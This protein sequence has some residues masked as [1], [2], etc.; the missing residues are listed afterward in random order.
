M[1]AQSSYVQEIEAMR[2]HGR[3]K[4]VTGKVVEIGFFDPKNQ[5]PP[6][7]IS[8]GLFIK[9]DHIMVGCHVRPSGGDAWSADRTWSEQVADDWMPAGSQKNNNMSQKS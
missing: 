2:K 5:P 8:H 7:H 3:V 6:P 1:K 9:G 4:T